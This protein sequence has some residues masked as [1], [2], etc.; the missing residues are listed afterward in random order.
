MK[1]QLLT[2]MF[3]VFMVFVGFGII[4]PIVPEVIRATNVS[5]VNLGFLMA[6]YSIGSFITSPFWGSLSDRKGRRPILLIG[7]IGF[8]LSFFIF[9]AA[10]DSLVMMYASRIVGGLFAGAVIPCAFAYASDITTEE[11]RTK[12]I[13]LLGMTIGLGFIFGPALGGL[14]SSFGL[15][16][17]FI[18]S[19]VLAIIMTIFAFFVLP[20]SLSPEKRKPATEKSTSWSD[21]TTDFQ[22]ALKYLYILSFFATF[23]LAGLEATFQFFQIDR[24]DAT[25]T[26]IGWMFVASG[27][28]QALIQGGVLQRFKKGNEKSLIVAGLL[29]SALGYILILFS[30]SALNAAIFLSVFTAGNA[31]I[32]PCV[33]SLITMKTKVGYGAASGISSSMDSLGRI[34]G[35][36]VGSFAFSLNMSLPFLLGGVLA[37]G[38]LLLLQRHVTLDRSEHTVSS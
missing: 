33:L 27:V 32:R 21:F 18:V 28:T 26:T 19:G 38:A 30:S 35:P 4:I 2:L 12:S 15:F 8:S 14:L 5:T 23:T 29:L 3:I 10:G 7:L 22:G 24:I 16:V 9:A 36:V 6:I 1:K 13:G 20:E 31:L 11:N 25:P 34:F 37:L 17:P